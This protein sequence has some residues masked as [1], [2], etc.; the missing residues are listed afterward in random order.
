MT[1]LSTLNFL[2]YSESGSAEKVNLSEEIKLM[3][4]IN[5]DLLVCAPD[6]A[7]RNIIGFAYSYCTM[8]SILLDEIDVY[9]N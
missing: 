7:V 2:V 1:N 4:D 6:A 5:S 8:P 3:E 9:K